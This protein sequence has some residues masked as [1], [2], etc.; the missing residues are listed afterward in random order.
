MIEAVGNVIQRYGYTGNAGNVTRNINFIITAI[1]LSA[2]ALLCYV[3]S[4]IRQHYQKRT[5]STTITPGD[6]NTSTTGDNSATGAPG[7]ITRQIE[8]TKVAKEVMPS[9]PSEQSPASPANDSQ[10]QATASASSPDKG[11]VVEVSGGAATTPNPSAQPVLQAT[12][13]SEGERKASASAHGSQNTT[14][15]TGK[16]Q[17][18]VG[19]SNGNQTPIITAVAATASLDQVAPTGSGAVA[20]AVS[21]AEEV[22][23]V[24]AAKSLQ[25]VTIDIVKD[26]QS[27]DGFSPEYITTQEKVVKTLAENEIELNA[28]SLSK[29][30]LI[31]LPVIGRVPWNGMINTSITLGIGNIIKLIKGI[32]K[33]TINPIFVML[34]QDFSKNEQARNFMPESADD[35]ANFPIR[36]IYNEKEN[37]IEQKGGPANGEEQVVAFASENCAVVYICGI[38][39]RDPTI[40]DGTAFSCVPERNSNNTLTGL[41]G[42][43]GGQAVVENFIKMLVYF[44]G[45]SSPASQATAITEGERKLSVSTFGTQVSTTASTSKEQTTVVMNRDQTL[46]AAVEALAKSA[47]KIRAETAPVVFETRGTFRIEA[48]SLKPVA[49][50]IKFINSVNDGFELNFIMDNPLIHYLNSMKIK[51]YDDPSKKFYL[52][53]IHASGIHVNWSS[54][55]QTIKRARQIENE[56]SAKLNPKVSMG[57]VFVMVQ[58]TF[59]SDQVCLSIQPTSQVD[60]SLFPIIFVKHADKITKT[61]REELESYEKQ[62]R[63]AMQKQKPGQIIEEPVRIAMATENCEIVLMLGLLA[64]D[65]RIKDKTAFTCIQE[66]APFRA[67]DERDWNL[68]KKTLTPRLLENFKLMVTYFSHVDN[69]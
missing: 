69:Q 56:T 49:V 61:T 17:T 1:A 48:A 4:K 31:A 5:I 57:P 45:K 42:D 66:G 11:I 29:I 7:S 21:A 33:I 14:A 23:K 51:L 20:S 36:F 19:N 27:G 25:P 10:S 22:A 52:T 39:V 67:S 43:K 30:L 34:Y 35:K 41:K 40:K 44:F 6:S 55:L 60:M 38:L 63:A 2:L 18:A 8:V 50:D 16:E 26:L 53:R 32:D 65:N 12:E 13:V 64:H 9:R 59:T 28:A 62:K 3:V 37:K 58:Q 47:T 24:G 54:M 46:R 15:S 68:L